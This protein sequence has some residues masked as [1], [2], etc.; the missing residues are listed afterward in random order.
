MIS[1]SSSSQLIASSSSN[2]LSY[3]GGSESLPIITIREKQKGLFCNV[4]KMLMYWLVWFAPSDALKVMLNLNSP[5]HNMV[6][7]EPV[8][9][10]F[11]YDRCGQDIVSPLISVKELR[12]LGVTLHM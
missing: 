12:E 11:I 9:K 5:I 10:L 1:S 7:P 3:G 8:W 6:T 2:N 4:T